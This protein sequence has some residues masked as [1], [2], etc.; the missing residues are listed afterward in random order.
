MSDALLQLDQ[1]GKTYPDLD[2]PVLRD[3]TLQVR[4]GQTLAIVGPSGCGK[5]TLLNLIGG[6]DRP[7]CGRVC[8]AGQDLSTLG[9]A[10]LAAYR[11]RHVGF[12][13]QAHHLL[14]QLTALENVLVPTLACGD[15]ALRQAA[16]RRARELLDRV[17]LGDRLHHRPG[18][19]SGGQRQRVA[20]VRA[21]INQPTMLL[22]DEPTGSLD[23]AAAD[24]V[25]DLLLQLS[26]ERGVAVV[27]ATHAPAL[28]ARA[29]CIMELRSGQLRP[30]E[31]GA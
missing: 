7:T 1:V 28:A 22:A 20:V 29:G 11:S 3:V 16:P 5:S 12:V 14:P 21:L 18:Q 27:L 9:D 30:T 26:V 24:Q 2:T 8:Y 31:V 17:G 13:F 10:E 15:A 6:L 19:L 23:A 25:A 4:P